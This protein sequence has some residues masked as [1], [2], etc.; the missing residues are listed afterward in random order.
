MNKPNK[1]VDEENKIVV[2][3]GGGFGERA[4]WVKGINGMV[5]DEN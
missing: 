5:M 3:R 1:H 4:K 2:T